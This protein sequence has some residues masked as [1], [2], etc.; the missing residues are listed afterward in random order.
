ML[1]CLDWSILYVVVISFLLL[2]SL[3]CSF[4][5]CVCCLSKFRGKKLLSLH[6][7]NN[8]RYFRSKNSSKSSVNRH[9]YT[10]LDDDFDGTADQV[11]LMSNVK[12]INSFRDEEEDDGMDTESDTIFDST[13]RRN[14][15]WNNKLAA[16]STQ[17]NHSKSLNGLVGREGRKVRT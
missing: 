15:I 14:N 17:K 16:N 7:R 11:E 2:L 6:Q 5:C 3:L 13:T 12:K 1:N 10:L 4:W 9:R 8:N